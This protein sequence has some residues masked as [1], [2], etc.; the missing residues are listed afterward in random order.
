MTVDREASKRKNLRNKYPLVVSEDNSVQEQNRQSLTAGAKLLLLRQERKRKR[1]EWG[2]K[3]QCSFCRSPNPPTTKNNAT[4]Q[5]ATV[6][7]YIIAMSPQQAKGKKNA[8]ILKKK[9]DYF[10]QHD[11]TP[12]C[13]LP[14]PISVNA[15][16]MLLWVSALSR[17]FSRQ[18][19]MQVDNGGNKVVKLKWRRKQSGIHSIPGCCG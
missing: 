12:W 5:W 9:K 7:C 6:A 10:F 2:K 15:F 4:L 13:E 14:L 17:T 16:R 3:C 8:H 11:K 1:K 19:R 18:F